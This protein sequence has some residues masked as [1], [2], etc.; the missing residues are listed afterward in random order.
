MSSTLRL[1]SAALYLPTAS[2]TPTYAAAYEPAAAAMRVDAWVDVDT[3]R[4]RTDLPHALRRPRPARCV[5]VQRSMPMSQVRQTRG[6][7][8]ARY[9][10]R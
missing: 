3:P 9:L 2:A 7:R 6:V 1:C 4:A 8:G 5:Q 10:Y